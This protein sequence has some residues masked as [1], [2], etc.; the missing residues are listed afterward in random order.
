M[1]QKMRAPEHPA[2]GGKHPD[3]RLGGA[4]N[5]FRRTQRIRAPRP[6]LL[7]AIRRTS[8]TP[9]DADWLR[10]SGRLAPTCHQAYQNYIDPE[11]E[12]P[13]ILLPRPTSRLRIVGSLRQKTCSGS[14]ERAAA[15]RLAA[16]RSGRHL[17]A[18]TPTRAAA[19]GEARAR[20]RRECQGRAERQRQQQPR[21]PRRN[22]H[23]TE[24]R[25]RAR[26]R[27]D[28]AAELARRLAGIAKG[29]E[30]FVKTF[31]C[32][33]DDHLRRRATRST[34]PPG[35]DQ[36]DEHT[37]SASVRFS[38]SCSPSGWKQP[39]ENFSKLFRRHPLGFWFLRYFE[40]ELVVLVALIIPW[41]TRTPCGAGRRRR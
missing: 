14:R 33:V 9:A 36:G 30:K 10:G 26:R 34:R 37:Q 11:L 40:T 17:R 25:G 2:L 20:P 41:W 38:R 5:R 31:R 28:P 18:E 35:D 21:Q 27:G 6:A 4:I 3:G 22:S 16:S 23:W 8:S 29:N 13:N 32:F 39:P 1:I 24:A 15:S 19:I 12:Q 7:L